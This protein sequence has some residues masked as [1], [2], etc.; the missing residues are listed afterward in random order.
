VQEVSE[1]LVRRGHD[2]TVLTLDC[3]TQRD[4]FSPVG[5][6]LPPRELLNG[7]KLVR[8]SPG[9]GKLGK[10]PSWWV[11]RRGGWRTTHWLTGNEFE[12]FLGRPSGLGMI[13]PLLQVE[14]DVVSTIN[15]CLG[16]AFWSWLTVRLRRIPQVAVPV[17]HI[18]QPWAQRQVY[19]RM[20]KACHAAIVATDAEQEFLQARGAK[21]V[22]VAG[23]GVEPSR[24]T[25]RDGAVIRAR[26]GLGA[27][28]IVGFVGRQDHLKGVPTLMQAM[29][30][31][32]QE[33]PEAVLLLAG[34]KAHRDSFVTDKLASLTASESRNV[35]LIDDFPD[36]D[37]PSILDACDLLA[38]PSVE[39]SFGQ[40]LVQAWMC[41]KPVIGADIAA[42]RR[43][44]D[45]GVNGWLVKPFDPLDL[46]ARILSLLA[47]PE[48]R[49]AFGQRGRAKSLAQYTWEQ[50]TDGWESAY[51]KLLT[52]D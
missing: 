37:G 36:Q 25:Q 17:L 19:S 49:A 51:R 46:A 43:V 40:V 30:T 2:V 16:A 9:G 44:V 18:D 28:P 15:W 22:T 8:V 48:T 11:A 32:W 6:G 24:F 50:V 14:A 1:R 34:P 21:A 10:L 38:Q 3:A 33:V 41:G 31:V 47:E 27:R 29:R 39:E 35:V 42:T 5:A 7:V 26:Y 52:G 12:F 23:G 45:D 20:F 4:F 13:P